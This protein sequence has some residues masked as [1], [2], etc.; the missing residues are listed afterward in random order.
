MVESLPKSF[1]S[2]YTL[3]GNIKS[4]S[5]NVSQILRFLLIPPE[6]IN[7]AFWLR[8]L[9]WAGSYYVAQAALKCESLLFSVPQFQAGTAQ[10]TGPLPI[11]V[12]A[13]HL[14]PFSFFSNHVL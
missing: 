11:S 6:N 4:L 5:I 1:N 14:Q 10:Q 12:L 8:S 9:V 7:S 13:A 3:G 2:T